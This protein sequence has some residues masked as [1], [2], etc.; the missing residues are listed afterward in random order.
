MVGTVTL[1]FG[2]NPGKENVYLTKPR[3]EEMGRKLRS[4]PNCIQLTGE[5]EFGIFEQEHH[6]GNLTSSDLVKS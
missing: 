6:F 4:Q 5:Q 3:R 1:C 2:G